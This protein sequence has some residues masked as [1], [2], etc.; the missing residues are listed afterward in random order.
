MVETLK[1]KVAYLQGLAEGLDIEEDKEGRIL[2]SMLQ[3]LGDVAVEIEDLRTG[4]LEL[5][6][7]VENLDDDLDEIESDLYS[8]DDYIGI[9]C[10]QCH[11]TVYFGADVVEDD[12][13]IEVTCPNCDE[14]VFVN[15][16][17]FDF[18]TKGVDDEMS[19]KIDDDAI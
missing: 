2:N 11:K 14:V 15:D 8:D 1:Q 4:Q 19:G 13:I 6:Q 12:D 17:S 16:G 5:E 3:I 7:Y 18:E 10:P 9:E